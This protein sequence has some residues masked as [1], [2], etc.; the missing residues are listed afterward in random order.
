MVLK[1]IMQLSYVSFGILQ[2]QKGW[3][4]PAM[5]STHPGALHS[6][7]LLLAT[8]KG[9]FQPEQRQWVKIQISN[10]ESAVPESN[11]HCTPHLATGKVNLHWGSLD[12]SVRVAHSYLSIMSCGDCRIQWQRSWR[13]LAS[14]SDRL[15]LLL[16]KDTKL[17]KANLSGYNFTQEA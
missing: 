4:K 1:R 14:F 11:P 3:Q 15:C 17:N 9:L 10:D 12:L 13:H 6:S 8:Q 16:I 7:Y 5:E 2:P